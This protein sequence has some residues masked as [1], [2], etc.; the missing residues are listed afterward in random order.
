[1]EVEIRPWSSFRQHHHSRGKTV[2]GICRQSIALPQ[3]CVQQGCWTQVYK[4]KTEPAE[5]PVAL[6]PVARA[7][8]GWRAPVL[9]ATQD[10]RAMQ[11]FT[12]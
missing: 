6:L 9:Q 2:L 10:C 4:G 1:M 11:V 12:T 8:R 3:G 5:V 7:R